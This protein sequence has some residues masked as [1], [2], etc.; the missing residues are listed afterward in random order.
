MLASMESRDMCKR[1]PHLTRPPRKA[2]VPGPPIEQQH[3]IASQRRKIGQ[4]V[5]EQRLV[6]HAKV[7]HVHLGPVRQPELA[8][9]L[10]H[11]LRMPQ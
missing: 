8:H 11:H 4:E 2:G 3:V 7:A 6:V 10:L 9:K 5:V 1:G